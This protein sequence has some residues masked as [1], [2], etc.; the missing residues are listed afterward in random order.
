MGDGIGATSAT[1][2]LIVKA[3]LGCRFEPA[4][5]DRPGRAFPMGPIRG[6]RSKSQYLFFQ[7]GLCPGA[8]HIAS[9]DNN[10][11]S[12]QL[13]AATVI[14]LY[15]VELREFPVRVEAHIKRRTKPIQKFIRSGAIPIQVNGHYL[16]SL[17]FV[18][19]LDNLH[20]G[21]RLSAWP[22]TGS[23]EVR[24]DHPATVPTQIKRGVRSRVGYQQQADAKPMPH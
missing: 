23:P 16:E 11:A 5:A 6:G 3:I 10:P 17:Y 24:V 9:V 2:H 22:A 8:L 18:G 19:A 14:A 12:V 20:P 7:V 13:L 4:L 21:E 1:D 15:L